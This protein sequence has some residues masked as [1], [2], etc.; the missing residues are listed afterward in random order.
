M[1]CFEFMSLAHH[2]TKQP[3]L[4]RSQL[5]DV[6]IEIIATDGFEALTLDKVCRRAGVSKGGLQYHFQSKAALLTGIQEDLCQ[7]FMPLFEAAMAAE[8]A[9]PRRV[10]RAYIRVSFAHQDPVRAKAMLVLMLSMPEFGRRQSEWLQG[11]MAEEV[12]ED[13]ALAQLLVL[14]RFAADG[15]WH[16]SAFGLLHFDDA[17]REALCER[18]LALTEKG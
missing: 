2:R 16:S 5:L 7:R 11:L 6:A 17:S 1:D 15:F 12:A 4:L 13:P 10:T 9:G 3:E 14:W 8:P 18:L